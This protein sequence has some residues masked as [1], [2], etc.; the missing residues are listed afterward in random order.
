MCGYAPFSE[1]VEKRLL[2]RRSLRSASISCA[3]SAGRWTNKHFDHVTDV[4][5]KQSWVDSNLMYIKSVILLIIDR[6][7]VNS[8]GVCSVFMHVSV[9]HL[10]CQLLG[11]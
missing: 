3:E 4:K 8:F 5:T 9:A 10:I 7:C 6:L 1:R 2:G 11:T